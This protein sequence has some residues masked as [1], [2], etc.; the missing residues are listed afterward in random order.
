MT[1]FLYLILLMIAL[2]WFGSKLDGPDDRY[3]INGE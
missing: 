2:Y 3:D 1:G